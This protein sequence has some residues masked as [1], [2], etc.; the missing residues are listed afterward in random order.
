MDRQL[1]N[2]LIASNDTQK[3]LVIPQDALLLDQQGAYVFAVNDENKVEMRRITTGPQ[4]GLS[5]VVELGLK[6]GDRVI[7]AGQQKVQPGM[8]VNAT[9]APE[10]AGN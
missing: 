10:A 4:R 3:Y 8:T 7:T 2:V 9:L 6:T 5:L 1:V